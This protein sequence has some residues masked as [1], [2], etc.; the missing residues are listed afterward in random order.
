MPVHESDV[1]IID[2]DESGQL[3]AIELLSVF[4]FAG[5]S[6]HELVKKG[7]I[8]SESAE[9]ALSELRSGLLAAA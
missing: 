6:L 1:C 8:S 2:F 5:A 9:Q 4:G 7:L 3:A